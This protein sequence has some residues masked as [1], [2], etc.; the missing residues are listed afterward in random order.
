MFNDW[1]TCLL[2]LLIPPALKFLYSLLSQVFTKNK[3]NWH[4]GSFHDFPL[5]FANFKNF[6]WQ[7][8]KFSDFW[9]KF[10]LTNSNPA[11]IPF[12]MIVTDLLHEDRHLWCWIPSEWVDHPRRI[13]RWFWLALQGV[14]IS[15]N[16]LLTSTVGPNI[17]KLIQF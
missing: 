4:F 16:H 14:V 17:E 3:I 9:L 13:Y 6:P 15:S 12:S 8:I 10:S 7:T 1:I 5:H 2:Q 11:L